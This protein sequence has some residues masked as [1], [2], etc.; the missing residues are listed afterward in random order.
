MLFSRAKIWM[1]F[2]VLL[3]SCATE[4]TR[5]RRSWTPSARTTETPASLVSERE[6]LKLEL[7]RAPASEF[8]RAL[9]EENPARTRSRA[10]LA[11]ARLEHVDAI[12]PLSAS[13]ADD[14]PG[15][16]EHAAFGLGQIGLSLAS[17]TQEGAPE[18]L[19][20][21]ETRLLGAFRKERDSRVRSA[22][23]RALGRLATEVGSKE[24]IEIAKEP[25]LR[26]EAL[27]ALGIAGVHRDRA[28]RNNQ[29]LLELTRAALFEKNTRIRRAAA[30]VA[31]RQGL[32]L[33]SELLASLH[34]ERDV[35]T[36][37]YVW[38]A[39]SGAQIP[40]EVWRQ[41]LVDRDWKVQVEV[42]R[43]MSEMPNPDG[44][45]FVEAWGEILRTNLGQLRSK[46][47]NSGNGQV[48]S[49]MCELMSASAMEMSPDRIRN[50]LQN[51]ETQL[52]AMGD[53]YAPLHCGCARALDAIDGRPE[54]VRR[55]ADPRWDEDRVRRMEVE[56]LSRTGASSRER[57]T[58]LSAAL[59]DPSVEVRGI[60]AWEL[61]QI[62]TPDAAKIVSEQLQVEKDPYVASALLTLFDSG[63]VRPSADRIFR[64]LVDRFQARISEPGV[65]PLFVQLAGL[66]RSRH[67]EDAR[68]AFASLRQVEVQQVQQALSGVHRLERPLG[69]G[70]IPDL[71]LPPPLPQLP[72][73]AIVRTNL[74]DI[75]L[76]FE[77][78]KTPLAVAN[79]T[80]LARSGFY[81]G[82]R[83]HRVE[84]GF[85][86]QVGDPRG[87]GAGGPGY[88]IPCEVHDGRFLRGA[89][90]M[91]TNARDEGGSQFFF[92]Y[93]EQ[94][95]LDGQFTL[96]AHVVDGLDVMDALT[97]DDRID[98]V[99][100]LGAVP[101]R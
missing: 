63:V 88:E 89:V 1:L 62:R 70:G 86:A 90:G 38:R 11:L 49:L 58:W 68:I 18:S 100:L 92:T 28:L 52:A 97:Q 8:R 93:A 37:I 82:L 9:R 79:F 61:A 95:H 2:C 42:L 54:S 25:E 17:S 26:A 48:T 32:S 60:A 40:E 21:I 36:K 6:L 4:P 39:L 59:Q 43:A 81:D 96:F 77:R 12:E 53:K 56:V 94:R 20:T 55:C 31:F 57:A 47:R 66:L 76:A 69:E 29:A 3:T 87:D 34:G 16:R 101:T 65:V 24:L 46:G 99:Q 73:G 91:A 19:R 30:F 45:A 15:V 44:A 80:T 84:P 75:R 35:Q 41:G 33:E 27:Y 50:H 74:G 83:F 5:V 23:L 13:L 7:S 85:V 22:I 72:L 98:S 51:A 10:T 71:S 64:T 78:Q 67:S 14:D